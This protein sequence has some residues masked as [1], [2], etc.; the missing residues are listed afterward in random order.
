MI[1]GLQALPAVAA[2]RLGDWQVVV[3]NLLKIGTAASEVSLSTRSYSQQT[4]NDGSAAKSSRKSR[5][6][7]FK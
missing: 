4:S 2:E 5:G 3:E 1:H 6:S 7:D